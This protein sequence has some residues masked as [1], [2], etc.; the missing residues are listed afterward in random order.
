MDEGRQPLS[1]KTA[2]PSSQINPYRIMIIIRVVIVGL[3]F[4]YRVT[5]PVDNA[6]ALWL[7]AVICELCFTLSWILDQFPKWLPVR[8]KTN[9]DRLSLRQVSFSQPFSFSFPF[10][11]KRKMMLMLSSGTRKMSNLRSFVELTY[12]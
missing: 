11:K 12:L 9:L 7:V 6:Y 5:H 4:H 3:F 10:L 8:R 2:I 1:R